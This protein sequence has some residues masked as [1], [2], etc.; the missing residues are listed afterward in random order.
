MMEMHKNSPQK[1]VLKKPRWKNL[2]RFVLACLL[3]A[4]LGAAQAQP[5]AANPAASGREYV[6]NAGDQ[7]HME[8]FGE[9]ELNLD[10]TVDAAGFVEYPFAGKVKAAGRT[11][12]DLR[13]DI[14]ARLK[15]GYFVNPQFLVTV[16][17]YKPVFVQ[18]EV[19]NAGAFDFQP[20]LTVRKAIALAGGMT[21]RASR[22]KIFRVKQQADGKQRTR[23]NLDDAVYPGDVIEVKQSFF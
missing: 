2:A 13:L 9:P 19:N 23:V 15:D 6:I 22:K 8:V 5:E 7:L 3:L 12:E 18:G 14:L 16:R 21:E 1:A 4:S 11:V 17:K 20:G 10:V